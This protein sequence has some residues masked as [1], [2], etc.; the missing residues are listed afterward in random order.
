MINL[1]Q[2]HIDFKGAGESVLEKESWGIRAIKIHNIKE[3]ANGLH[4]VESKK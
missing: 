2:N 1:Q 4:T 3:L